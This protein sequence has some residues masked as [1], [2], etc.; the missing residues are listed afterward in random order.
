M[1]NRPFVGMLPGAS[2][3][4]ELVIIVSADAPGS[5]PTSYQGRHNQNNFEALPPLY[6]H[7]QRSKYVTDSTIN[8][9]L[10]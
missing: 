6:L 2:D 7:F 4:H 9:D 8:D 10:P 1:Q 5:I 3:I